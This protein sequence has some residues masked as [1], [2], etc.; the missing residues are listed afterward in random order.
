MVIKFPIQTSNIAWRQ[1]EHSLSVLLLFLRP[2]GVN[3]HLYGP[4][5]LPERE[6]SV[7]GVETSSRLILQASLLPGRQTSEQVDRSDGP[8]RWVEFQLASRHATQRQ[9]DCHY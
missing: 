8:I 3:D 5:G 2:I 9:K 7:H 1:G 6:Q 4:L